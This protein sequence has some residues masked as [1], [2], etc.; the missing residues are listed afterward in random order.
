MIEYAMKPEFKQIINATEIFPESCATEQSEVKEKVEEAANRFLCAAKI[1]PQNTFL[2]WQ[3][4]ANTKKE[5][6][7]LHFP[8][9]VLLQPWKTSTGYFILARRWKK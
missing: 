3:L 5:Y 8:V 7:V 4:N 6:R 1:L 2:G 9:K